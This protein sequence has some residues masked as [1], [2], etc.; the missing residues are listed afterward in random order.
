MSTTATRTMEV[1]PTADAVADLVQ[2]GTI[3]PAAGR[4]AATRSAAATFLSIALPATMLGVVWPVARLELG[5]SL[6]ALGLAMSLY[7]VARLATAAVGRPLA[8]RIGMGSAFVGGLVAYTAACAALAVAPTWTAFVASVVALGITSGVLDSLVTVSIAASGDVGD[9]GL[10]HGT[11]GVGATVAPL[12]VAAAPDWRLALLLCV[13]AAAGAA[14]LALRARTAWPALTP[15]EGASGATTRRATH[16]GPV[17][18]S[19]SVLASVVAV[20]VSLSQW[21]ATWLTAARGLGAPTAAVAVAAFW[22]GSTLMRLA[23]AG[24]RTARF[25][26]RHGLARFATV[27]AVVLTA[28]VAVPALPVAAAVAALAL[29]GASLAPIVPTRFA[30]TAARVG[31]DLADRVAGWQLL[32]FNCGAIGAVALIGVLV[33]AVGSQAAMAVIVGILTLAG[34]PLLHAA[35]RLGRRAAPVRRA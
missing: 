22:G 5:Q 19:L 11:F 15:D 29:V 23:M 6:G 25:V 10:I 18:V 31:R 24:R 30:T 33:D 4:R 21:T 8:R 35:D 3:R 27:A 13:G 2:P 34:L 12:L 32:A 26:E 1:V 14:A 17:V 16:W 7:G 20:E 28:L 9:A